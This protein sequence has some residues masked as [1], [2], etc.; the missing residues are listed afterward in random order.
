MNA[1][2]LL[3]KIEDMSIQPFGS[4]LD[5]VHRVN[6]EA[7]DNAANTEGVTVHEEGTN[8]YTDEFVAHWLGSVETILACCDFV[9]EDVR[10]WYTA[11]GVRF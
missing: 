7:L 6:F 11:E 8:R 5:L 2:E 4:V 9:T 1:R 10:D 3:N